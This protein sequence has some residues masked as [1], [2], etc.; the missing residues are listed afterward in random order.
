MKHLRFWLLAFGLLG[1]VN[2]NAFEIVVD[3]VVYNI[4][5]EVL[6]IQEAHVEGFVPGVKYVVIPETVE[7]YKVTK[8]GYKAFMDCS[9]VVSVSLPES[10]TEIGG[11]AFT[12]CINLTTINIPE[13]ATELAEWLFSY[14]SSLTTVSIP[15][16]CTRIPNG[17]FYGCSSLASI[18]IPDVVTYISAHSFEGT[19]LTSVN[20]PKAVNQIDDRAFCNCHFL[21]SV[22]I[23]GS[24]S[25]R[26]MNNCF[27]ECTALESVYFG[28]DFV[29]TEN[30]SGGTCFPGCANLSTIS[31]PSTVGNLDFLGYSKLYKNNL[32]I[33]LRGNTVLGEPIDQTYLASSIGKGSLTYFVDAGM[34]EAYASSPVW[35]KYLKQVIS[36]DMLELRTVQVTADPIQSDLYE[37]LGDSSL[38]VANLKLKGSINGYD[39]MSL[40]N[41][42]VH[43]LYLDLSEVD[44]VANDGGYKYYVDSYLTRDNDLGKECFYG[45]NIKKIILPNSLETINTY[46]FKECVGLESVVANDGLK[47]IGYG[48]FVDCMSLKTI[49]LPNSLERLGWIDS[50]DLYYKGVGL[51]FDNC[52]SLGPV[53]IIPDKV[54][55]IPDRCFSSCDNLDS[56]FIG[57]SVT[58][59]GN[60]AFMYSGLSYVSLGAKVKTI[61]D[62][63]FN[64]CDNLTTV[65]F[66]NRL[67]EIGRG[68]FQY[69]KKL[70][71]AM[72]PYSVETIGESAFEGCTSLN[73]LKIP[74]LTRII[75]DKAFYDC[76]N[77]ENIYTY[78][79]EPT[80]INQNTFSCF[81]QATLNVPKTSALL[82][83]YNTQWSQFVKVREFEE[84]YDAFYLN[85]DLELNDRTGRMLGEPDAE[86]LPNSGLVVSGDEVQELTEIELVHDG[87]DGA[88]IIGSD[89]DVTGKQ[90]NLIAK[91]M[92]VSI[93]VEGG[94][95]YFFCFPFNVEHD[96][97]ECSCDYVFYAYDG[98]SRAHK[99]SGWTKMDSN[100]NKLQQ[101]L[102]YI[103]QASRSGI[104]TI[105]VGQDYLS[106]EAKDS[107]RFLD[108]Y[109]AEDPADASWNF[110]GNPFISYYDVQDL[111]K[112]YDAPIVVW[113]GNGYDAYRPGD[114]DYQLKPFEAF[115]VQKENGKQEVEFLPE[116]RITYN[117][118]KSLTLLRARN[119]EVVGHVFDPSRQIVNITITNA[120]NV[121]DR[122][123]IVYNDKA[124]M[125]YEIGSDV[126]K[127]KSD[128]IPQVYTVNGGIQYAIN[129]RPMGADDIKLGYIAP[130]A[131]VYTLAVPRHDADVEIYDNVA[132]TVVDFTFGDYTFESAAGTFNDRF[133]IR[134]TGGVTAIKNG[135]RLD[136]LSVV[137]VDGGLDIEGRMAGKVSVYT[138]SGM[139]IAEPAKTGRLELADGV[140]I[141]KIGD[142]SVKI[143]VD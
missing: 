8:I 46:A 37:Q 20:I 143:C 117:E 132:G 71:E 70:Q 112:E 13:S 85:G 36:A 22:T 133:V 68:A 113:N 19:A 40:R 90:V 129:E 107:K 1:S 118:A 55:L 141:I 86:M 4:V 78:T 49:N 63:A 26:L 121:T 67:S 65:L 111:A 140:Y 2:S 95:W 80:E 21:T 114:D 88:T 128:G 101:G 81:M 72:I 28:D 87:H 97:I 139:L 99:N 29:C 108:G 54:T 103:F 73:S 135:F 27:S 48:A 94:R 38:Y 18:E 125:D 47:G 79:V 110:V 98:N 44:I 74:S 14:C 39:I 102:G 45:T 62:R 3:S 30:M 34:Y 92:K 93:S 61:G 106:F 138:E 75:G 42:L 66:N 60:D 96:S 76:D 89:G 120:D 84:P 15:K 10:I 51:V 131:G 105:H 43:L 83:K 31:V 41:K 91:A 104:L 12:N 115:F 23:Q 137:T 52:A 35:N 59:I 122:T 77:I 100:F 123:R 24:P 127:F 16:G 64:Y 53:L 32:S 82:Y 50:L 25:L 7:G 124:Q 56:V 58:E 130:K 69:C 136:G 109:S 11:W 134:K 116:N 119:R 33:I 5:Q 17:I 126:S 6:G 142:K 9:S 57:N